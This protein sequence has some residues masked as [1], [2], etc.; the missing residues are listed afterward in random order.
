[1]RPCSS[2]ILHW[3]TRLFAIEGLVYWVI[4]VIFRHDLVMYVYGGKY[5]G[6]ADLLIA[7]G[8]LPLL[9]S[10]LNILGTVLRALERTDQL[11]R[12]TT[13]SAVVSFSIGLVSMAKWGVYG[14]VF[15]TILSQAAQIVAI[16]Y[17][18]RRGPAGGTDVVTVRRRLFSRIL[19]AHQ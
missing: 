5:G 10:R 9:G 4:V 19:E 2:R 1:L 7:L 14:A 11:F 15:A 6:Y 13:A 8:A 12:A 3:A 16:R 17:Y 18:V